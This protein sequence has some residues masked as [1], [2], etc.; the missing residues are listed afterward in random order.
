MQTGTYCYTLGHLRGFEKKLSY[1]AGALDFFD[2]LFQRIRAN[3]Y[4]SLKEI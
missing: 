4:T 1:R 2:S 3:L